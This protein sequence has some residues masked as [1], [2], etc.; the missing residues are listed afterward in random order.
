MQVKIETR[1]V[2]GRRRVTMVPIY[3]GRDKSLEAMNVVM[4]QG[5]EL[6]D[7]KETKKVG[8]V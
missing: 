3:S 5:Y 1:I 6:K 8:I 7:E 4:G 2:N